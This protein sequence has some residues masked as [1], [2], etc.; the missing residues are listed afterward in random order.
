MR[1]RNGEAGIPRGFDTPAAATALASTTISPYAAGM[2]LKGP[3][4]RSFAPPPTKLAHLKPIRGRFNRDG[5]AGYRHR[6]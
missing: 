1:E 3:D 6:D 5:V 2:T 4:P